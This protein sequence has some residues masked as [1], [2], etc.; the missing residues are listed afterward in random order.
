MATFDGTALDDDPDYA[1]AWAQ[2]ARTKRFIEKFG[3]V[4]DQHFPSADDAFQRAFALNPDLAVAH[5][6]YT[7]VQCDQGQAVTAM[8]R[9]L[10]RACFRRND[11][12]LFAGLV[13]ACR[14]C[15]EL[16]ASI[17]SH[18]RAQ[19]LDPNILTSVPH[20]YFLLGE[21]EKS[22][23]CYGTKVGFYLDC[24]AL[25]AL[26]EREEA[27]TRLR[28]REESGGATG[29]IRAI[30]QSLRYYLEGN[31]AECLKAIDAGESHAKTDPESFL[32]IAR[33]LAL[34]E[35]TER[36]V[37]VLFH[38]IEKGFVCTSTIERD[39]C[40]ASLRSS[41]RYDQLL[42][43]AQ[44]RRREAHQMFLDAGGPELLNLTPADAPRTPGTDVLTQ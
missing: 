11:P 41:P 10:M 17:A 22:L 1:P 20:T 6:L 8:H 2:L 5:N 12:D 15:G 18:E 3:E 43:L 44:L 27:L 35:Q 31:F 14:Y 21:Y 36:A 33:Q 29:A 34:I 32:Y 40:F 4:A 24:A 26:G 37:Q 23:A 30:M 28:S 13:Q 25:V 39:P 38:V 19:S 16:E 7:P 9:L 42:S